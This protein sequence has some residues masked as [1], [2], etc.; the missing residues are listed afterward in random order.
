M[1]HYPR[2]PEGQPP[3]DICSEVAPIIIHTVDQSNGETEIYSVSPKISKSG[4][5]R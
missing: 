4:W 2:I 5:H 3:V 1:R